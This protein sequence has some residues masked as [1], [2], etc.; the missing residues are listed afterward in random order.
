MHREPKDWNVATEK[1]KY[2]EFVKC[3]L[4]P[5]YFID[6]HGVAFNAVVGGFGP[7]EC[8]EYQKRVI[9][10]YLENAWNIILKSRQC[11]K[12]DT[13]VDTPSGPRFIQDLRE[14]DKVF[15]YN[16]KEG[17]MEVDT[18]YDAWCSGDKQCVKFKLQDTRNFEVGENHPFYV[19]GK[20]FVKAQDLV[21]GDEILDDNIGFGTIAPLESEVKLLA[22]LIT[23][24]STKRQVKFTNNNLNYLTEFEDSIHELFPQLHVRHA[25]KLN[26]FDYLPG[27][28]HGVNTLNPVMEW[29]ETKNI[30]GKLTAEKSLPQ[31]V[32]D[33]DRKSIALLINRMFAGDGWVSI[34]NKKANKRLELGIASPNLEFM[35]QV[36]SLLNKF[37]IRSNIY[38][39]KNM[40]LQK[41]RF[42]KLRVTHSKSV[43][44]FVYQI[45]I[46]DKIRPEHFDIIKGAQ[47]N[48]KD[49]TI[50]KTVE[51]TSVQKCYDISVD[52]NENF[53][54]DGLLTHNTGL[55][56]ITAAYV[57]WRLMFRS[58]ERILI[59]ANN[60]KGAKRFLSYVKTFIDALPMFLQPMNGSKEGRV[61]WNDTRIEFSNMS[62]AESVAASPQA[63]RGEQLSLVILDEF[64]FVENDKTIWTA[65]NFALSMSKGDC[66]MISTPYGSGNKYHENWVE[67]EKGK[68]GFNPI[69][70]HWTENPVCNKGLRQTIEKGKMVFWSP[71]YEDQRQKMNHDSVLIAQELD[72]SFLG[73]KLLAVDE[74]ILSDYREKINK[75]SP[76]EWYFD[77]TA[78]AFTQLKNEFWVWK[79]PEV[80]VSP[81]GTRTPVKYIVSADV[82][83]GDGKDYSAIQ[84][85][86]VDTLEQVAEYQGKIDPDLFANMI[87]A[88]GV[89]YNTAFVVV[90]GNSF[91]LATTYKL[92][93]NLQYD[94][95]QIF[96][97]K[98]TKKIHVRPSGYEDY[99]VDEDEKIPGFQ[100]TFQSK[101]MVVDAI[102]RSMREGSVKINSVRLLNEFNT[103][104]MENVS[105][106]KVVAEAE[107]GYNDDLIM[108]LGIGLYIRETEYA[109]IVVNRELTKSMLDAFSTSSS[110]M[111]GKQMSPEEKRNEEQKNRDAKNKNRGLFYFRD[112]QDVDGED[113]PNDLSWL[114]G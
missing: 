11:L 14:G 57:A 89:A 101:V 5:V 61:K 100:T 94:K 113:D 30:A 67:A 66:I 114:M 37:N 10:Q 107:S 92:T 31:E 40:K 96:Y 90:E 102:R 81:D 36:K 106:D 62:W 93:R 87:Y 23:D 59:L 79:R 3:A 82:A 17:R 1:E 104:V 19:K 21:R 16:L 43:A 50:I 110:P 22:Y 49:G 103:W 105:K 112:G 85:I 58:N 53:F 26:G 95:N 97:S 42:F 47:H 6:R 71:W 44:R 52:K 39:V 45:G 68:G 76:V 46:Y 65:I 24:G 84:V 48:V 7:I 74:T 34:M 20:G 41:S 13:P 18:V 2:E 98:S 78:C 54:V 73:S 72:L 4:D 55:S 8:Y 99:V 35:H 91:G 25:K 109:N 12:A 63:G 60:G 108:A 29:C 77:H 83:R 9:N 32:F 69:K 15:S 88:I 27:Q 86:Q 56:V 111:Y 80:R 70:V 64:A 33:W 75:N 51:K 28:K 38:E